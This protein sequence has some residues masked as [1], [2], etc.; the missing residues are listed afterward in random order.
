MTGVRNVQKALLF[1]LLQP[2]DLKELQDAAD[3]TALMVKQ[4][5]LKTAPF[6]DVWEEFLKRE[7]VVSDY[8]PEI[9]AYEKNV[10]SAR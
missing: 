7:Q 6:G 4:E 2:A 3:F 1:A 9:R 5:A 8:L 10:L